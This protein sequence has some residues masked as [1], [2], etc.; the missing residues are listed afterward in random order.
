MPLSCHATSSDVIYKTYKSPR[1]TYALRTITGRAHT[2]SPPSMMNPFQVYTTVT[3]KTSHAKIHP[4]PPFRELCPS[5]EEV[6]SCAFAEVEHG[7]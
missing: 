1:S 6:T 2:P 7:S 5:A 4:P 3:P